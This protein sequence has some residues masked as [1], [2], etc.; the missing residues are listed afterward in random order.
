MYLYY[1]GG[2]VELRSDSKDNGFS[3]R[4]LK[5]DKSEPS[6]KSSS[7]AKKVSSSSVAKSSSSQKTVSSS[8]V[9][10]TEPVEVTVSS[11]TDSRDGQTYKTVKIGD[12]TWMAQN[13]NYK[14]ENSY[15]YDDNADNCTKYGRLYTWAAAMDSAGSW[16]T[17][18][19]GCGYNKACSPTYLVRGVCPEGWLL[20]SETEWETLFTAVGGRLTAGKALK[21]I[22][23][24]KDDNGKSGNGTDAFS[25]S[26]LSAGYRHYG[27]YYYDDSLSA[28]FWRSSE[29]DNTEAYRMILDYE[30][31]D[32]G[33]D[34]HGKNN[35]Y[36]VRCLKD[37]ESAQTAKSSSSAKASSSSVAK[38]SSSQKTVSS[39]SVKV[40]DPSDVIVDS[41][42]D[43]RDG[44]TYKTVKIGE[45]T[46]MAENL[47]YE[48]ENS[49]CGGGGGTV[50][51][52][53]S[54]YG[55]LYTWAAAIGKTE[56]A[57]G[58][59]HSCSLPLGDIQG[60]CSN[61]WH[62]PSQTEWNTLF[63][64]VGDSSTVGLKLKSASGWSGNGNG[65]D[66][67]SFSALPAG[68]RSRNG[69]YLN[70]GYGSQFWSSEEF[71]NS[72]DAYSMYLSDSSDYAYLNNRNKLMGFSVRCLK[73]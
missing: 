73:D 46:W 51:G 2:N 53:C 37:D 56:D 45:Q 21:S 16:S 65:T 17:N 28:Y 35:G 1:F 30:S 44:Q 11:M 27:G 42:T 66:A 71:S 40:V 63:S 9:K 25:F 19:K 57:C 72:N 33:L 8:S 64:V 47:N 39:S 67:F 43:S 22:F 49:W 12:Q 26:A 38:S 24:W 15:C 7:S 62:L 69:I 34:K 48:T 20:P 32:A 18:G 3:V 4:C 5:D 60:I 10:V 31:D 23:G 54:K 41:M 36:S 59:G 14:T 50:Q 52:D 61:G 13:L 55:R 29:Y 70:V 68:D 58:Y 6:A